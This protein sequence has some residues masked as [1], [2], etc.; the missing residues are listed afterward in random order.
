MSRI[1]VGRLVAKAFA[2]VGVV[3]AEVGDQTRPGLRRAARVR[4]ASQSC[5][6]GHE[7]AIAQPAGISTSAGREIRTTRA[8]DCPSRRRRPVVQRA[9]VAGVMACQRSGQPASSSGRRRMVVVVDRDLQS[10][11][12]VGGGLRRIC[13]DRPLRIPEVQIALADADRFVR[14]ADEPLDVVGLR[15]PR[16]YLKTNTSQRFGSPNLVGELVDEDA[17]A[18]EGQGDP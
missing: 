2:G 14:Q 9:A 11:L 5:G 3:A 16:G 4:A 6:C 1:V 15:V 17:V 18:V 12:L 10:P 7:V 13:S 8:I